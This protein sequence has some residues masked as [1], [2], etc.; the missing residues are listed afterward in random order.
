MGTV[1]SAEKVPVYWYWPSAEKVPVY[2]YW[3]G[4]HYFALFDPSQR[5]W[6]CISRLRDYSGNSLRHPML[7]RYQ[8]YS[9]IPRSG[10]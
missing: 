1:A 3:H 4:P 9:F 10:P 8:A 2:W 6:F 5:N 7:S